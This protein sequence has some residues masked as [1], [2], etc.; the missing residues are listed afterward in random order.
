MRKTSNDRIQ[1]TFMLKN[2]SVVFSA[3]K[4]EEPQFVAAKICYTPHSFIDRPWRK[5]KKQIWKD[6]NCPYVIGK[7][8]PFPAD[9]YKPT[10]VVM[11]FNKTTDLT[12]AT[13]YVKVV[14]FCKDGSAAGVPCQFD[15]TNSTMKNYF[16][17]K[18]EDVRSNGMIAAAVIL[19]CV[20]PAFFLVYFFVESKLKKNK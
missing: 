11:D 16:G 2:A 1:A 15:E 17:T 18:K 6:K 9:P 14:V 7:K 10:T 8:V 19:S 13:W 4:G 3:L 12:T 5:M 20:G